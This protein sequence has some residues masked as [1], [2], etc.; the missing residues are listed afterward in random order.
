[1]TS[2]WI[3]GAEF[4]A[5]FALVTGKIDKGTFN[6][7]KEIINTVI[8]REV[9]KDLDNQQKELIKEGVL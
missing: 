2:E 7:L 1:M 3:N 4:L 5:R 6:S 9:S 8:E